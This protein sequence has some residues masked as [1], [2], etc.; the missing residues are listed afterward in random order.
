MAESDSLRAFA[1]DR[2]VFTFGRAVTTAQEEAV[3]ALPKN[4]T[5]VRQQQASQRVLD[6]YLG[7]EGKTQG[8]FKN[9]PTRGR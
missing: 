9:P 5:E 3:K 6:A 7:I 2:A 8:R 4:A 1:I